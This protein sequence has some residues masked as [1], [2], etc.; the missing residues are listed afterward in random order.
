MV[1]KR[2]VKGMLLDG[3]VVLIPVYVL[4]NMLC[5]KSF[6]DQRKPWKNGK[7]FVQSPQSGYQTFVPIIFF[8]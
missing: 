6:K 2:G 5:P 1:L 8:S 3:E 7:D 4:S